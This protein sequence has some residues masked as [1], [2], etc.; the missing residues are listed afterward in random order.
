MLRFVRELL[1]D[2]RGTAVEEDPHRQVRLAVAALLQKMAAADFSEHPAEQDE[3]RLAVRRFLDLQ[4]EEAAGLVEE[5]RREAAESVSLFDFTEV[6]HREL[7]L[8][9]KVEV[10]ELLWQIA[11]SDGEIHPQEEHLVRKVAGL[12]H[13]P[14]ESFIEAKRRARES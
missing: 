6:L 2:V 8:E 5:G 1:A 14:H 7:D 9:Q 12:L 11:Y 4:P 3:L 10:V 13:V